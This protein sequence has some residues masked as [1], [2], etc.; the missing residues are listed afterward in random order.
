MNASAAVQPVT[1]LSQISTSATVG[2]R[3]IAIRVYVCLSVCLSAR[4]SQNPHVQVSPNFP[5]MLPVVVAR[6][7]SD[8]NAIAM[9]CTSGLWITSFSHNGANGPQSNTTRF[10]HFAMCRHWGEVCRLRLY[11]AYV[12]FWANKQMAVMTSEITVIQ[13]RIHC[14]KKGRAN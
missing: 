6:S 5:Y 3:S 12:A 1:A 11:L 13:W 14:F 7:S 9:L 2:R 8:G 4:T 10:V